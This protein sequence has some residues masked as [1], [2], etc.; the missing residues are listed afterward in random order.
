MDP[1]I[2]PYVI[3]PGSS[4]K[5][6]MEVITGNLTGAVVI[7]SDDGVLLGMLSDGDIRRGLLQSATLMTPV[8]KLM[9]THPTVMRGDDRASAER[10]FS[11]HEAIT[12]LP[13]VDAH[14]RV[15]RIIPRHPV[16]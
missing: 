7:V 12:L 14:N 5:E 1:T 16:S 13:V 2:S 3:S 15:V 6:A 8:E 11:E 4:I 9:N 10:I